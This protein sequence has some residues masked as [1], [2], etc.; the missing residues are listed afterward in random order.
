MTLWEMTGTG[1]SI[2]SASEMSQLTSPVSSI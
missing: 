2:S 1:T